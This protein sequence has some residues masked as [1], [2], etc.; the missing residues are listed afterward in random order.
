MARAIRKLIFLFVIVLFPVL[1]KVASGQ[2]GTKKLAVPERGFISSEQ[3]TTWEEG[4][5][6]GNGT[7]G[8]NILSRPLDETVIFSHERLFLPKGPPTMPPDN[9]NRLFEIRNLI[10]RGLYRQATEL[11]FDLSGQESFMYPDPFVPAF[12]MNLQMGA[13]GEVEKYMRSVD[14]QTGEATVHWMDDRGVFERKMF[15]SRAD[16][17]A[18]LL[19]TGPAGAIDCKLSLNPRKP[20]DK[21]DARTISRSY[22]VYDDHVSNVARSV[23]D[24]AI[25][26]RNSFTKAYPGSIHA[27][28]GVA[29]V[30]QHNGEIIEGRESIEIKGADRVLVYIDVEVIYDPQKSRADEL[31]A[32]MSGLTPDYKDMLQR[33]TAIHGEMFN[34][35]KL[36]L[37]GGK[38][39]QLT[40]EELMTKSTNENMNMALLEKEFDAARY[41]IISCIGELPPTL[42]GVWGGTY[43]PG[44]ASDFTHNGNVPSAIASLLMG[45]MEELMLAYTTYMESVVPYMEINAKHIFNSRGIVLPS[46]S[47]TNAFNNALAGSFAGGFWVA[48]APWAAHFFYDYYLYTGD[49]EFLANHALPF[50]EKAALFFEDYLYEGADGKYIFSPT[51]SPENTPG[52]TNSQGTF[53]ATMDVAAARELLT[54]TIAASRELG[55]NQD[56]ISKWESMITRLPRYMISEE[57]IIK[58]WLTPKLENNDAHRH[59]SQLYPLY[60][61]I[62]PE[63]AASPELQE[64][65]K[66]SIEY[67]LDKHWR[68][69]RSGF[70]SFGLVQLGQAATSLGEGEL[71][72]ECMQHLV[73]RFWLSNMA[74]MHNHRS[75]FN[76]DISGGMPAVLIKMLVASDPGK[77][78]LLPAL[79]SKWSAGSIEGVLCR[80]QIEIK[81]LSWD[82][83]SI[84]AS[85]V[86]GKDQKIS[87][88]LPSK[89]ANISIKEG[90]GQ[91]VEKGKDNIRVISLQKDELLTIHISL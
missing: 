10:D 29:K 55:V 19:I 52:N 77:I 84:V 75:L 11:A 53:N 69:N 30:I 44:W 67:K 45:N 25:V 63:I 72:Y 79:P 61:G 56:Q 28:E 6:S 46:R 40:T 32:L 27:L 64:A 34:R 62:T 14:F 59:S 35:M 17:M 74:S 15:V 1:N 76:M 82:Q 85:I 66:K 13:V 86:S 78:S 4:L 2:S 81:S 23:E 3:A 87:L 73:N 24:K 21:L 9:A 7:I 8:I 54:S 48:G 18:V 60:D 42:Q 70:M 49:R 83:N 57:G 37:G 31:K 22:Q 91:A 65:F 43:V 33:H 71:A 26:F 36:D 38:D 5:I 51:Q 39:H 89:I 88:E 12:D 41:N 50:M 16:G 58:E 68:G 47:T 80:G 90:S 20:S